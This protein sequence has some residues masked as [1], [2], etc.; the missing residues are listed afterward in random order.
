MTIIADG[1]S[2][3]CD[4]ILLDEKGDQLLKTRT[5]G[6]N[7]A[8]VPREELFERIQENEELPTLFEKATRVDFYGAGCGT[9]ALRVVNLMN[10]N[11]KWIPG[12]QRGKPVK[13]TF[14]L[15]ITFNVQ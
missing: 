3:K 12:Q 13:V 2:T 5:R 7:P 4:W 6:L 1:G 9:E 11:D 10:K 8:V 15:P 14:D